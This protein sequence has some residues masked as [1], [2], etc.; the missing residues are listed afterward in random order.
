MEYGRGEGR[1]IKKEEKRMGGRG[2][3]EMECAEYG[4]GERISGDW[5]GEGGRGRGFLEYV[6]DGVSG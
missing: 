3:R 2:S 4:G 6:E 5:S 1:G